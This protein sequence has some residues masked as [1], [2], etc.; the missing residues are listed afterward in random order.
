MHYNL[1]VHFTFSL[2]QLGGGCGAVG[3]HSA[4]DINGVAYWMSQ[5]AFFLYDG[6]IRKLPCSVQDFVLK[7][8]ARLTN[9]KPMQA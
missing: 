1:L 5:N 8:L 2:V 9:Q 3:V 4:V 6:T 7:I